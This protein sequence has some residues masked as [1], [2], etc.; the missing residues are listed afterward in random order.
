MTIRDIVQSDREDWV[1]LREALWPGSLS[2]H[3]TET[4]KYFED[5]LDAPIVLVAETEGRIVGFVELDFRKYAPGC[6]S[7]PVAFIEG[8]HVDIAFR[9]RGIGRALIEAAEARA[10][11]MG[12]DE[13]A[14]DAELENADGIAALRALEYEEVERVV[15]FRRSLH[16]A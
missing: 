16:D 2:D 8:W 6:R 10:R 4:R 12:H 9:R 1:R 14:S 13:I 7:S 3:E 15:C 5:R 11:A